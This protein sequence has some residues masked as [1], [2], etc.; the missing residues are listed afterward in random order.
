MLMGFYN[1][2][3]TQLNIPFNESIKGK[4]K[5]V[6]YF[7]DTINII[8][9]AIPIYNDCYILYSK[10]GLIESYIESDTF[11][12]EY[13]GCLPKRIFKKSNNDF[14][15]VKSFYY[16]DSN[17]IYLEIDSSMIPQYLIKFYYYDQNGNIDS[18]SEAYRIDKKEEAFST[19]YKK[20]SNEKVVYETFRG[21]DGLI[22]RKVIEKYKDGNLKKRKTIHI[23]EAYFR[24]TVNEKFIIKKFDDLNNWLEMDHYING[25]RVFKYNRVI[26]FNKPAVAD[27]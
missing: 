12:V 16:K 19:I 8:N 22:L 5:S 7:V 21:K 15:R 1:L 13:Q 20:K 14:R 17:K 10:N 9:E 23:Q 6:N 18:Y 26:K 4:G 24:R 27:L 3:F 25:K 2:V 11:V